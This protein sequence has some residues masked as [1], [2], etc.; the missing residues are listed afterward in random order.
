MLTYNIDKGSGETEQLTFESEKQ[1]KEHFKRQG[2]QSV[3]INTENKPFF[4]SGLLSMYK[5]TV[6]C[7]SPVLV[8]TKI[9]KF[10]VYETK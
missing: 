7:S 3:K 5:G 9:I 1:F 6:A 10:T 8:N 4:Q 2:Y